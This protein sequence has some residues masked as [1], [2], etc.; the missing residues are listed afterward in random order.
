MLVVV[1]IADSNAEVRFVVVLV[2]TSAVI[3]EVLANA[4]FRFVVALVVANNAV[5]A[6]GSLAHSVPSMHL[7]YIVLLWLMKLLVVPLH[8]SCFR[9]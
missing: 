2:A 3:V 6:V 7:C 8:F 5:A 1:V 4:D 9:Y